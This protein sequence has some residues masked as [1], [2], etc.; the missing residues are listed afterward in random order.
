MS[1]RTSSDLMVNLAAGLVIW[2]VGA[3]VGFDYGNGRRHEE[4]KA[5][6]ASH[7]EEKSVIV[8]AYDKVNHDL[9]SC[10]RRH[11]RNGFP[12]VKWDLE[13]CKESLGFYEQLCGDQLLEE[14][15]LPTVGSDG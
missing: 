10:M 12:K 13:I 15:Q 14:F 2:A 8:E 11:R 1:H 9:G 4:D 5:L 7:L 3:L 6:K